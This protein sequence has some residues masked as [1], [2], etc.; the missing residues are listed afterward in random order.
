MKAKHTFIIL[1]MSLGALTNV[2]AQDTVT[3]DLKACMCYAVEH[4]CGQQRKSHPVTPDGGN[5]YSVL[6]YQTERN[7]HW[8]VFVETNHGETQRDIGP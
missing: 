7:G 6:Y 1:M 8:L 2:K 5:L 3:M 4:P